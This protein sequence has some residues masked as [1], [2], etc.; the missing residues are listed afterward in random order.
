[1]NPSTFPYDFSIK[2]EPPP[3]MEPR[4]MTPT[5]K[6]HL[7]F[8][9]GIIPCRF[10]VGATK[11]FADFSFLVQELATND[12]SK[13]W[14]QQYSPQPSEPTTFIFRGSSVIIQYVEGLK[15]P[16]YHGFCG[17]K[18]YLINRPIFFPTF[19]FSA[20]V[21]RFVRFFFAV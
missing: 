12:S 16:I 20:P 19:F 17:Q 4:L 9:D 6:R 21:T 3:Q 7:F 5:Y 14:R 15:P 11:P 18:G 10:P 8:S 13:N 1:M 2:F